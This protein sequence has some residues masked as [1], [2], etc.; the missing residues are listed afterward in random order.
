MKYGNWTVYR[1]TKI[2]TI[3]LYLFHSYPIRDNFGGETRW[4]GRER[5][6]EFHG[7]ARNF[8]V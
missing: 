4:K 5:G 1:N 3:D 8:A 2:K 7:T 6:K